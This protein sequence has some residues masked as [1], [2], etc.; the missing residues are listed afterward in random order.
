MATTTTATTHDEPHLD[1]EHCGRT[2]SGLEA[3][4]AEDVD[5]EMWCE[6]CAVLCIDDNTEE[7]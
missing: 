7:V 5:G 1:C 6:R 4:R 3:G 2:L